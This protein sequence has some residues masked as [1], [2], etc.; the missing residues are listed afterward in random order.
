[1]AYTLPPGTDTVEGFRISSEFA[2]S[3][4]FSACPRQVWKLSF[5]GMR[6]SEDVHITPSRSFHK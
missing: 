1:M 2:S 4:S 3:F 6:K 5:K